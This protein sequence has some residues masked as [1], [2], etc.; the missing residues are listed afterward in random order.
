MASLPPS[1]PVYRASLFLPKRQGPLN[2]KLSLLD[3]GVKITMKKNP[4]CSLTATNPSIINY[5]RNLLENFQALIPSGFILL[6]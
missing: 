4:S 3:L 5:L 2:E 1:H 6:L